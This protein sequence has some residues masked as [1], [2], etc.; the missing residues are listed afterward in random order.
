MAALSDLWSPQII[1]WLI[2]WTISLALTYEVIGVGLDNCFKCYIYEYSKTGP[3]TPTLCLWAWLVLP[4]TAFHHCAL[5]QFVCDRVEELGIPW[6]SMSRASTTYYDDYMT[7]CDYIWLHML[8]SIWYSPPALPCHSASSCTL[9]ILML[10]SSWGN[11]CLRLQFWYSFPVTD[12]E[13][14]DFYTTLPL[15]LE[16]Y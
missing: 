12:W 7:T 5:A 1:Y 4:Y 10:S 9:T 15:D 11:V 2:E 16:A 6:V 3:L 8:T 14:V 13:L